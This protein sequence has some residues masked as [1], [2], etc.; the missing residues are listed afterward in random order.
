[1]NQITFITGNAGKAKYLSDYFHLPVLHTKLDLPEIQS[2]EPSMVYDRLLEDANGWNGRERIPISAIAHLSGGGI[3]TKLG[4]LLRQRGLSAVLDDLFEPPAIAKKCLEW[5][6][7]TPRYAY[8]RW[9]S[10][11]G[12]LVVLDE[13]LVE[14]FQA[15]ARLHD[16]EARVCGRIVPS[17]D[18]PSIKIVSKYGD[19]EELPFPLHRR[20]R[21][22]SIV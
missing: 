12:A 15:L 19:G 10:G 18:S 2:A 21:A 8:E 6:K 9:N 22:A 3:P 7:L 11:Q 4:D 5:G 20:E 1:M 16:L 17:N 14:D 13:N